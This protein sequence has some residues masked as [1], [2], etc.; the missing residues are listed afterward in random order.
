M[1]KSSILLFGV[2]L[3]FSCNKEFNKVLKS[4]D[5]EYKQEMANKYYDEGKFNKAQQLFME[6]F[7]VMKGSDHFED[8]Y[9]KYAYCAY[10]QKNFEEAE[11]LFAGY[12]GVFPNHPR[13]EEIAYMQAYS[14]YRQSPKVELEQTNT[15]KAIG[16]MQTFMITYPNSSRLAEAQEVI[17]TCREK[18]EEKQL[19]A[20]QLYYNMGQYQAAG[21]YYGDLLIN[22]PD[23]K[24]G[25]E[26]MLMAVKSYY[27]FAKMSIVTKQEERYQKVVSEYFDFADRYPDSKLLKEA[28]SYKILSENS[29][30]QIRD[31]Q[32]KTAA[33]S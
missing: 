29:I 6:L 13:A 23:S 30:K 24:H 5:Y 14:F 17:N 9:Y 4:T 20:A 1:K 3:L 21:I 25:E 7:P 16:M 2:L 15:Q 26:Y 33:N 28:E 19:K 27:Q 8:L 12:L 32:V 11:S 22:Y 10:Y 18:L 31:E